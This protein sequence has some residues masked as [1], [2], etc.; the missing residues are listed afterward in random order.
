MDELSVSRV[1]V[2]LLLVIGLIV[3]S[4]WLAKRSGLSGRLTANTQV[5]VVSKQT[6]A[7]RSSIVVVEVPGAQ[8]ILGVTP[9]SIQVLHTIAC[10]TGLSVVTSQART[11]SEAET[12][13]DFSAVL[14]RLMRAPCAPSQQ[15]RPAS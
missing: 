15:D 13:K 10:E 3:I 8:L 11:Q 2:A 1:V 14:S 6:L 5:R 9:A 4:G 12:K 7:A